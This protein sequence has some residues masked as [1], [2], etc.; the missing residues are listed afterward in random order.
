MRRR[1]TLSTLALSALVVAACTGGDDDATPTSDADTSGPDSVAPDGEPDDPDEPA[2]EPVAEHIDDDLASAMWLIG[3]ITLETN[4]VWRGPDADG[5]PQFWRVLPG[6]PMTAVAAIADGH[7]AFVSDDGQT[8]RATDRGEGA[9]FVDRV[10]DHIVVTTQLRSDGATA[11]VSDD[12]GLTWT[13]RPVELPVGSDEF[14]GQPSGLHIV[15]GGYLTGVEPLVDN[16]PVPAA[17]WRSD[18]LATW[19]PVELAGFGTSLPDNSFV[20]VRRG[21]AGELWATVTI[22]DGEQQLRTVVPFRSLDGGRSFQGFETLVVSGGV[23]HIATVADRLVLWPANLPN[24]VDAHPWVLIPEAGW[25]R[26]P[27]DDAQWGDV[28][29]RIVQTATDPVSG[30]LSAVID[31]SIIAPNW[32][33]DRLPSCVLQEYALVT[34][35]DGLTWRDISGSGWDSD[36]PLRGGSFPSLVAAGDDSWLLWQ[37]SDV[38]G[39]VTSH[40]WTGPAP[41]SGLDPYRMYIDGPIGI[42]EYVRTVLDRDPDRC[43]HTLDGATWVLDPD[44]PDEPPEGWPARALQLAVVDSDE[45]VTDGSVA[46]DGTLARVAEDRMIF[47]MTDVDLEFT[48][49]PAGDRC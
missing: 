44:L 24:I 11:R 41:L 37:P 2:D 17:V 16:S 13:E 26:T 25:V 45:I 38:T 9:I 18:D 30:R 21:G 7:A 36:E 1:S 28:E 29:L 10:G 20:D 34:S 8:F 19:T 5:T 33:L 42:G 23:N 27:T 48:L 32:C 47:S 31:R 4:D 15:D 46:F 14:P 3:E 22:F 6:D 40:R 39:A 12:G 49:T 35:T 43:G